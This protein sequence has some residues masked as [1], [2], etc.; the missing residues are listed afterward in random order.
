M[1]RRWSLGL[2]RIHYNNVIRHALEIKFSRVFALSLSRFFT[3]RAG[4]DSAGFQAALFA[5]AESLEESVRS[6]YGAEGAMILRKL[7]SEEPLSDEEKEEASK[8]LGRYYVA[9][10]S[11]LHEERLALA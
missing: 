4:F 8:A 6:A 7:T 3:N 1:T 10:V 9:A 11:G 5:S 2:N